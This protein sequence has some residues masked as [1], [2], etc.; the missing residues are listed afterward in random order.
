METKE[1]KTAL[2]TGASG[3]IGY[4]IA[5]LFARDG[6]NLVLVARTNDLLQKIKTELEQAYPIE[7]RCVALDLSVQGNTAELHK[8]CCSENIKIDYLINN[9]GYGDYKKVVNGSANK[10]ENMLTLNIIAL[11]DLT[12]RFLKQMM[13]R[14]YGKILNVGSLAAFQPTPGMAAYGASKT[15]VLH[16]TE[17]L[18]AELEGSG[19]TATVINPGVTKTGFIKRADMKESALAQGSQLSAAQV[20]KEGY[21]GMF[22]G[23]L[24][25]VPGLMNSLM[26]LST[27]VMPSRRLLLKISSF[28]MRERI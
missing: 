16:F 19:V 17:A 6:I 11:T 21:E 23:K 1:K 7:V 25:V 4:E 26:A 12:T 27:R 22:A 3:G 5:K 10:Y 15:Y 14:G 20:A 13:S 28:V 24:N 18:H 2:V 8:W 9:A